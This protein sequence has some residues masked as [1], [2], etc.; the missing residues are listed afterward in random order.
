MDQNIKTPKI[1]INIATYNRGQYIA[2]AVNSVLAQTFS[3]WELLIVDDASTDNTEM[4]IAPYLKDQRIKYFKNE[5][6]INVCRTR[7]IALEKSVG[8]YIAVLDS[9]DF[10][11]DTQKLEKQV[12][13]L[14]ANQDYGVVG[15]AVIVVN[16]TGKEIKRFQHPLSDKKIKSQ[17][18]V[19]NPFSHS[20][21]IFPRSLILDIGGYDNDL[22]GI[23]DYPLWLKLGLNWKFA[24]LPD[25]SLK[26]RVH[27]LNI[28]LIGRKRLMRINLKL[29]RS[30]KHDYP[31][32]YWAITRRLTRYWLYCLLI[33][34]NF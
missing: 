24:N 3:D 9:D 34:F 5:K 10:W 29:I 22:N 6:N 1:S 8:K 20:S 27:G 32:Y 21:T 12:A 11:P 25:Y 7:N 31:H 16:K 13:F 23:E 28:S 26:Y 33:W 4:V 15:T 14:E 30:S 18:L 19:K 2:E 17:L